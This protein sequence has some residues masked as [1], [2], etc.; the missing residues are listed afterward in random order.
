MSSAVGRGVVLISAGHYR[1]ASPFDDL[2]SLIAARYAA[3]LRKTAPEHR[4]GRKV[5]PRS[6]RCPTFTKINHLFAD[7]SARTLISRAHLA[8][9]SRT[10]IP[11]E[12]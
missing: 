9:L 12:C 6:R 1:D 4:T 7:F 8:F 5:V 3:A 11:L 2:P 10:A